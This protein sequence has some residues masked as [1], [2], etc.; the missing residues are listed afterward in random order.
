MPENNDPVTLEELVKVANASMI[1][2]AQMAQRLH[3]LALRIA[4]NG[5]L[6]KYMATEV[7]GGNR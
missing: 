4:K 1:T 6:R 7:I 5:Y 3:E 2:E